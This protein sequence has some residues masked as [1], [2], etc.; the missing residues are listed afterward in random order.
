MVLQKSFFW[1][2]WE[3]D[4]IYGSRVAEYMLEQQ[5]QEVSNNS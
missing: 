3:W 4:I 1:L 2:S 5:Q